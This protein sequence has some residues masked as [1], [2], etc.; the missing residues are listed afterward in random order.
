MF[1]FHGA[2]QAD[3]DFSIP[4]TLQISEVSSG[5]YELKIPSLENVAALPVGLI[6]D[7]NIKLFEP[8]VSENVDVSC[9]LDT[10][11]PFDIAARIPAIRALTNFRDQPQGQAHD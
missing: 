7:K 8:R 4:A 11:K 2:V 5:G 6:Q 1:H 10:I 9:P 3:Y